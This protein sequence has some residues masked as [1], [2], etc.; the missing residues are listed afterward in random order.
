MLFIYS[1][2]RIDLNAVIRRQKEN[3]EHSKCIQIKKEK[4]QCKILYNYY[5]IEVDKD[6][7][8]RKSDIHRG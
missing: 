3:T 8:T 5:F 7:S 4:C 2:V 6:L 1:S